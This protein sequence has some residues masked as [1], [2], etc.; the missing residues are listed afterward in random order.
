MSTDQYVNCDIQKSDLLSRLCEH[1]D[2]LS[3]TDFW[4]F[5]I[6]LALTYY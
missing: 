5:C 6:I 2:T 1:N 4:S 3:E